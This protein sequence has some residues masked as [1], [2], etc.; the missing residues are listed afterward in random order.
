MD[1]TPADTGTYNCHCFTTEGIL[2]FN[3]NV[4]VKENVPEKWRI[5]VGASVTVVMVAAAVV[6]IIII[7][8]KCHRQQ[9]DSQTAGP[10]LSEEPI[11]NSTFIGTK[12]G[13]YST[14]TLKNM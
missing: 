1:L 8:R 11:E 10:D 4:T 9:L 5:V 7:K 13:L 12:G 3:L 6:F 14:L 2:T